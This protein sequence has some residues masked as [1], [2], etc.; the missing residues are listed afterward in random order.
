MVTTTKPGTL[1][2]YKLATFAE[3][4]NSQNLWEDKVARWY[5]VK[6]ADGWIDGPRGDPNEGV[7]IH[8]GPERF[9]VG[10][11]LMKKVEWN[12]GSAS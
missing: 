10:H 3:A 2:G 6:L 8:R 9:D 4:S 12:E 11:Y 5:I 1:P 7:S